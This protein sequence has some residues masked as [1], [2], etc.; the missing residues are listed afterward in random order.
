MK[1]IALTAAAL[2]IAVGSAYAGSGR[3]IVTPGHDAN[4]TYVDQTTTSSISNGS[5]DLLGSKATPV[6][7]NPAGQAAVNQ[8]Q[9]G[10]G[11]WGR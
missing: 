2:F 1:K 11:I 5:T 9:Y 4:Q 7:P 6:D 3:S 8:G 10:Q